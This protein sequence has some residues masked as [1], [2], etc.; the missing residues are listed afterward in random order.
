MSWRMAH[1]VM[2]ALAGS[3]WASIE[4]AAIPGR[5]NTGRGGSPARRIVVNS[6]RPTSSWR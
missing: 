5:L 3:A 1:A 4:S 6:K 2:R